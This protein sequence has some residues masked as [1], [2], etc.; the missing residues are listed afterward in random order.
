[1]LINDDHSFKDTTVRLTRAAEPLAEIGIISQ[2]KLAV[3]SS[4]GLTFATSP[5]QENNINGTNTRSSRPGVRDRV[6]AR[7]FREGRYQYRSE[8]KVQ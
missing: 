4:G 6:K 3:G 7:T 1:M 8:D 2:L 5:R